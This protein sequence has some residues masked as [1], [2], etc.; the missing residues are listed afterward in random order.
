M[1]KRVLLAGILDGIAMFL[2]NFVAH[3][4]LP[5]G[6]IGLREIP[7]EAAVMATMRANMPEPG[8][9]IYPGFGLPP[10]A[11]RAQKEAAMAE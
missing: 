1:A 3:D 11:S 9:Y 7:N 8:L 6:E 2:W 5:L 10:D 4:L